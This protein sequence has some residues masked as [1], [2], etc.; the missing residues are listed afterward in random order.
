M[1]SH[2]FYRSQNPSRQGSPTPEATELKPL[3]PSKNEAS[4]SKEQQSLLSHEE[5]AENRVRN[6]D[7]VISDGSVSSSNAGKQ[8]DNPLDRENYAL[9]GSS[10]EDVRGF[11][12][13]TQPL[14]QGVAATVSASS[15]RQQPASVHPPRTE[16]SNV[17]SA[18][19]TCVNSAAPLNSQH[20]EGGTDDHVTTPSDSVTSPTCTPLSQGTGA[21][22]M[23]L[24][25][26]SST[27]PQRNQTT[28]LASTPTTADYTYG[29]PTHTQT[30]QRH[31]PM[32][33]QSNDSVT[34]GVSSHSEGVHNIYNVSSSSSVPEALS[35]SQLSV[36]QN[37]GLLGMGLPL[38]RREYS[39]VGASRENVQRPQQCTQLPGQ[40]SQTTPHTTT[41]CGRMSDNRSRVPYH[42]QHS[43]PSPTRSRRTS[44]SND[45]TVPTLYSQHSDDSETSTRSGFPDNSRTVSASTVTQRRPLSLTSSALNVFQHDNQATGT[46]PG[47]SPTYNNRCFSGQNR[48]RRLRSVDSE[49]SQ[50]SYLGINHLGTP[51]EHNEQ[52]TAS[53]TF[54]SSV[55]D[56]IVPP[57]S[58]PTMSAMQNHTGVSP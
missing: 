36:S 18:A 28:I 53:P 58:V 9:V 32:R 27:H 51:T 57:A 4:S 26:H 45:S 1:P 16:T 47:C 12:Q 50:S 48:R 41:E 20:S 38:N 29:V 14:R 49:T 52:S 15:T 8:C 24:A 21:Q 56:G 42:S 17:S 37:G 34:S 3:S 25:V 46:G 39:G 31:Q 44:S 5:A 55:G 23:S 6:G 22:P 54:F 2:Y 33:S 35:G 30:H 13:G 40:P 10:R 19:G 7:D 43:D 11:Q